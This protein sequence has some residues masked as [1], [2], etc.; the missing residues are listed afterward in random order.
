MD[1]LELNSG[2]ST[3]PLSAQPSEEFDKLELLDAESSIDIEEFDLHDFT[4]EEVDIYNSMAEPGQR[5]QDAVTPNKMKGP[6]QDVISELYLTCKTN[7]TRITYHRSET[8]EDGV[9]VV[10]QNSIDPK[11]SSPFRPQ[12]PVFGENNGSLHEIRPKAIRARC[13]RL[14]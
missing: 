2:S 11:A 1:G 10:L 4:R 14:R 6:T 12:S 8:R 9:Y 13:L 3:A 7:D 5:L